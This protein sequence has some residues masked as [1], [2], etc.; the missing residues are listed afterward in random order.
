MSSLENTPGGIV[1]PARRRSR[2]LGVSTLISFASSDTLVIGLPF[3]IDSTSHIS[4]F[5]PSSSKTCCFSNAFMTFLTV[6]IHLSHTPPW[7]EAAGGLNVHLISC[8]KRNSWTWLWFHSWSPFRNSFSPL[9]KFPP[10]SDLIS[11]GLPLLAM[12]HRR[13]L[14]NDYVS[15]ECTISMWTALMVRHVNKA[16]YH[17]ALVRPRRTVKGPNKSTPTYERVVWKAW[18]DPVA[19]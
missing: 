6:L 5:R 10:L 12:N 18:H 17:L 9:T 3:P 7:W 14:I 16:P 15:I 11:S 4:V 19:K 1:D 13:A 8:C 2:R